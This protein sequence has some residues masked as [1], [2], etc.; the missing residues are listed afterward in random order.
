[1]F[2]SFRIGVQG[3]ASGVRLPTGTRLTI[4]CFA[5][6]PSIAE[7]PKLTGRLGIS[8]RRGLGHGASEASFFC[9]IHFD[10]TRHSVV[11]TYRAPY[12]IARFAKYPSR[13]EIQAAGSGEQAFRR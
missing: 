12:R 7:L 10:I 6:L 1:M 8:V 9:S 11:W 13:A 5:D 4:S 2:V 3:A